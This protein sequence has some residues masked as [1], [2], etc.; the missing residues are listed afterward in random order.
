MLTLTSLLGGMGLDKEV[1]LITDGRFSGATRG[2]LAMF[3][4]KQPPGGLSLA[5][6]EGDTIVYRYTRQQV[7]VKLS[8]DELAKRI[9]CL[10]KFEP[11]S[12]TVI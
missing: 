2:V 11:R 12:K 7:E 10:G 3:H 8:D 4:P 9:A 5:V 1:A 6:K